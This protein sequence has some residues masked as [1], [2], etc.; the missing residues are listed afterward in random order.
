MNVSSPRV[1]VV[2]P[3]YDAGTFLEAAVASVL[4]QSHADTEVIVVDDGSQDDSITRLLARGDRVRVERIAN[5][6]ACVARNVGLQASTGAYLK[7]LDADDYLLPDCIAA[8]VDA[9][10]RLP[11]SAFPVGRSYRRDDPDTRLYPHARRDERSERPRESLVELIYDVPLVSAPLYRREQVAAVQG[12]TAG[13]NVRHDYDFFVRL[14]IAGFDPVLTDE[15]TFVYRQHAATARVSRQRGEPRYRSELGMFRRLVEANHR[16]ADTA[17][18]A[19]IAEGLALSAWTSGRNALR[20]GFRPVAAELFEVSRAANPAR[21]VAGRAA[22]RWVSALLGPFVAEDVR[23]R[24][25]TLPGSW[26]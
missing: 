11:A 5:S 8:Q 25:G 18:R 12:F 16:S 24:F 22:Y 10:R 13:L 20:A 17:R 23:A 26:T 14:L 21:H 2:I 4:D 19:G 6:G 1:S 9:V 7:F 3:S 15:P